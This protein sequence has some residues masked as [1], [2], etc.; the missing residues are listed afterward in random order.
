VQRCCERGRGC[1]VSTGGRSSAPG[2]TASPP[3]HSL[4]AISRNAR[5]ALPVDLPGDEAAGADRHVG[6]NR[7][8]TRSVR[9]SGGRRWSG[10]DHG[11]RFHDLAGVAS[12]RRAPP[13]R[14]ELERLE[15]ERGATVKLTSV[16]PTCSLP[17]E[18]RA[19]PTWAGPGDDDV[20]SE[21][22]RRRD[23]ATLRPIRSRGASPSGPSLR[24]GTRSPSSTRL[25][26]F[27]RTIHPPDD[28]ADRAARS[29]IGRRGCG[30]PLD[31]GTRGSPWRKVPRSRTDRLDLRRANSEALGCTAER[32]PS[33]TAGLRR[34]R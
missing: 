24:G 3:T 9:R 30:P 10:A 34:P 11:G 27:P 28:A 5:R 23:V 22:G 21:R 19:R 14:R 13:R 4:D 25:A 17:R 20:D 31:L 33:P 2:S 6:S 7:S 8:P 18:S 29:W 15:P 16:Y 12:G 1:P 32:L 26:T